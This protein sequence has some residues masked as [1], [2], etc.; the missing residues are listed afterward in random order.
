MK[1]VK[2]N[3]LSKWKGIVLSEYDIRSSYPK[4][5]NGIGYRVLILLD[6]NGNKMNRRIIKNY[7]KDWFS[8]ISPFDISWVNKDW[9]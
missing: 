5:Y 7:N 4:R 2:S 3:Y 8:K 9:F 1:F 6:R